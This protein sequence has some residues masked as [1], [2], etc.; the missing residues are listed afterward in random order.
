MGDKRRN[1][2]C[3]THWGWGHGWTLEWDVRPTFHSCPILPWSGAQ[4]WTNNCI[5]YSLFFS[6]RL[7]YWPRL[8]TPFL[9]TPKSRSV[10]LQLKLIFDFRPVCNTQRTAQLYLV[11]RV[12][13]CNSVALTKFSKNL[14]SRHKNKLV[15]EMFLKTDSRKCTG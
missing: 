3:S 11:Y 14:W 12:L 9:K 7:Y 13:N 4:T 2:N 10:K 6:Y 1:D 5:I 8:A 15:T